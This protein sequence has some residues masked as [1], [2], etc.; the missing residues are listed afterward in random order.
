MSINMTQD[1]EFETDDRESLM[2]MLDTIGSILFDGTK[3]VVSQDA[4]DFDYCFDDGKYDHNSYSVFDKS[5]IEHSKIELGVKIY[6]EKD[7]FNNRK[8]AIEHAAGMNR[9]IVKTPTRKFIMGISTDY[10]RYKIGK[11]YASFKSGKKYIE[12]AV[13][14]LLDDPDLEGNFTRE[15]GNGFNQGFMSFD[16]SIGMGYRLSWSPSGAEDRLY[17]SAVHMY[18]GK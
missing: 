11:S 16:G 7:S 6:K 8:E 14:K 15:C 10:S 3:I 12:S 5:V 17:L 4:K 18:Y 2:K 13:E 1:F 9:E